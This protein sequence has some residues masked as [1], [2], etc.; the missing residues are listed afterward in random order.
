MNRPLITLEGCAVPQDS[1]RPEERVPRRPRV[2]Y[3][4][5]TAFLIV[6]ILSALGFAQKIDDYV[7]ERQARMMAQQAAQVVHQLKSSCGL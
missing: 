2:R 4:R 3:W 5:T 7:G 1:V 6:I